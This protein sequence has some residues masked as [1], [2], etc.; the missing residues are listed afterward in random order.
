MAAHSPTHWCP[1]R[2][3]VA[4]PSRVTWRLSPRRRDSAARIRSRSKSTTASMTPRPRRCRSRS[5]PSRLRRAASRW[6]TASWQTRRRAAPTWRASRAPT[7]TSTTRTPTPSWPAR[8]RR[9][10]RG[11][12][13]AG[14][15]SAPRRASPDWRDKALPSGCAP[16]TRRAFSSSKVS[17]SRVRRRPAAW[18]STRFTTTA[19]TTPCRTN[20]SSSTTLARPRR[21]SRAGGFRAPWTLAFPQIRRWPRAPICSWPEARRRS[22]RS[23]AK[24][25]SGRGPAGCRARAKRSV[26]A[27]RRTRSS[28][29]SIT[30]R[31][32]LGRQRAT[33]TEPRWNSSTRNSTKASVATGA[34]RR[35]PRSRR[36][37]TPPRPAHRICNSR[38]TR[39]R[40]HARSRTRRRSRPAATPS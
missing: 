24:P 16:R 31:A 36:R 17:R 35:S 7:S 21:T 2:P 12:P 4:L 22:S 9:T 33:A 5:I 6:I 18:S 15:N 30:R 29:K 40:Q 28:A 20:S 3:R 34:R 26:C 10:T 14:T 23:L 11:L 13:S 38:P 19:W 32:F 25:R 39:H 1:R 8:A 37:R 27:T